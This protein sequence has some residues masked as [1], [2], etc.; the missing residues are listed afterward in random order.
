[1]SG[2]AE[3]SSSI[4]FSWQPPPQNKTNGIIRHYTVRVT[5][6]KTG[7]FFEINSTATSVN[8]GQLQA[9]NAYEVKSAAFTIGLGPFSASIEITTLEKGMLV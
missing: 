7:L 8:I 5:E 4:S 3:T 1:M 2:A 9:Y 6:V